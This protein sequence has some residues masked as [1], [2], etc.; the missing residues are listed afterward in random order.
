M[1]ISGDAD[2]EGL[3]KVGAAVADA[4]DTALAAV[5]PGLSTKDLDDI[6]AKVLAKHG[7]RSAPQLTY[8]FPGVCCVSVN[9]EAAHG[10]PS[11]TRFLKDGDLV[12]IDVS[13]ELDGYWADTG[14]STG[15]GTITPRAQ[16]LLSATRKAQ[17]AAMAAAQAGKGVRNLAKAVQKQARQSGFTVIE[18]LCGHGLGRS[19]HDAPQLSSVVDPSNS[20]ILKDGMVLAI[21]PFLSMGGTWAMDSADG[22]T[23]KTD[24]GSLVAQF[25]H[26]LIVTKGE[27]IIV[28][29][30]NSAS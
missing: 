4:R 13:A 20:T 30:G 11:K 18:N 3:K 21:E 29:L 17:Q 25:E 16:E 24:D 6:A 15:V 9:N 1:I 12:N 23:L 28:T 14:A 7:A 2:I 5:E 22:W 10:I 19:L 26:T 27:P 8:K